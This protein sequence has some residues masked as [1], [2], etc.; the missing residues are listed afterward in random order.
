MKILMIMNDNS[1]V[2]REYLSKL[3]EN[4]IS[5]YVSII[6]KFPEIDI[7]EFERC[8]NY[9][10]PEQQKSLEYYHNFFHFE[11]LNSNLFISFLEKNNFNLAIQGGTGILR[12]N[13]INKFD[14]GI[15][16]F[17]PGLLPQYRG[18]SAPEWQL[19]ENN[20]I[21]TTCHLIDEGIDTGKIL[22]TKALSV[23]NENY[24]KFRASIYPLTAIFLCE[25]IKEFIEFN[26][27]PFTPYSQDESKARYLKYIGKDKI[28]ILKK[29]FNEG[30]FGL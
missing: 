8:Q 7:S 2:G 3:K 16:N 13:V 26:G 9:W 30:F 20:K 23:N 6:G 17:H 22:K 5:V 18:C 29:K 24:Y 4:N 15:I 19:Y 28:N 11:S 1:Y 25:I 27:N 10:V 14:L 12:N 21:F